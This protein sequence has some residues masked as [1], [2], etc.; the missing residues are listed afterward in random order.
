MNF[1]LATFFGVI[2]GLISGI[3]PGIGSTTILLASYAVLMQFEP[4]NLMMCYLAMIITSQYMASITAIYTGVPAP[5][6]SFP[7]AKESRNLVKFA[8]TQTAVAQNALASVLGNIIGLVLL[9][10]LIPITIKVM[11]IFGAAL[12]LGI[13]VVCLAVVASTNENK[14]VGLFSILL[15]FFLM[16]LG[17]NPN[18]YT[19]NDFGLSFLDSGVSWVSLV[20]GAIIGHNMLALKSYQR[21]KIE[22]T[23]AMGF[24]LAFA[25]LKDRWGALMRG[26]VLGFFIGLI[27]GLSYILSSTICYHVEQKVS[28]TKGLQEQDKILASLMSSDAAHCSGTMA[29]LLPFLA[30]GIPIT[31]G[32]GVIYNLIT[33]TT[34][35][36][37]VIHSLYVHWPYVAV[38]ILA[39]NLIA[40]W[41]AWNIGGRLVSLLLL[42]R[43]YLMLLIVLIGI[44]IVVYT[45]WLTSTVTIAVIAF[46]AIGMLFYLT[47]MNPMPFIFGVLTFHIFETL[48]YSVYQLY[49]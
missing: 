37:E 44:G 8:L 12:Q 32:E 28:D 48:A 27:P 26:S 4:V 46:V 19:V 10:L 5:E 38:A 40:L 36:K 31:T 6:S 25:S 33:M 9:L 42:P 45:G 16:Y 49:F 2:L 30:M 14:L 29:M 21:M 43:L 22:N 35:S 47:E 23:G 39:V 15:A 1:A 34:T 18:T 7:A 3:V 24:K 17:P 13:M 20:M 41:C 11:S